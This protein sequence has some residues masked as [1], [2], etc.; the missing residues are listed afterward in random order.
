MRTVHLSR[1][2]LEPWAI[3]PQ[4]LAVIVEVVTR[5]FAGDKLDAEEVQMRI[6]G[7]KRPSDRNIGNVAVLP[8]FG[9]IFPRA[10]LFTETS[11]GTSAEIYGKAFDE[12][13][14]N[15]DIGAIVLDVDSPG[16]QVSGVEELSKKIFSARGTKPIVAVANHLAASA[17]YWI[18]T[19]ADELVVTPSAEVGSIGVFTLH[20]DISKSLEVEGVKITLISEGK[21]KTEGNPYE[22][23]S[24]EAHQAIRERVAE[25]YESFIKAVARNRGVKTADVRNGFGEGRVVGAQQAVQLGMADRIATLDET[26]ERLQRSVGIRRPAAVRNASSDLDFRRRRMRLSENDGSVEPL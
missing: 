15:P 7:A 9:T 14:K 22:P 1:A 21:F 17:A 20:E 10:N 25:Y 16:G 23:L 24:E 12:L 18:A 2:A 4:N 3:L 8:L 5:H 19:A 6:N 11:G 26:I 13:V